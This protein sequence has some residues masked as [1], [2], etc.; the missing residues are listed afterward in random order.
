MHEPAES[1]VHALL[2]SPAVLP[3][4]RSWTGAEGPLACLARTA[5]PTRMTWHEMDIVQALLEVEECLTK[6]TSCEN[7]RVSCMHARHGMRWTIA[8][9]E[10]ME[11][12]T[13]QAGASPYPGIQLSCLRG[14]SLHTGFII[15]TGLIICTGFITHRAHYAQCMRSLWVLHRCC[16]THESSIAQCGPTRQKPSLSTLQ[17]TPQLEMRRALS[18]WAPMAH[19]TQ[20]RIPHT[21]KPIAP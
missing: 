5:G 17:I 8:L 6:Q 18:S 10:V 7:S 12:L 3:P 2:P 20:H 21:N 4:W 15:C 1:A 11:C 14:T 19:T 9:L 16:T 13:K